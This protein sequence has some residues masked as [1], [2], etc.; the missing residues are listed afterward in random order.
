[1]LGGCTAQ[2]DAAGLEQQI[3]DELAGQTGVAP[4][5]VDCPDDVAA[6]AGGTFECTA[7]ADDGTV[8]TITVTQTDDQG[9]LR[10]EVTEVG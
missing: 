10:W 5:S 6:E 4:S 2:I 9:N 3:K 8:A 7:V 1:M